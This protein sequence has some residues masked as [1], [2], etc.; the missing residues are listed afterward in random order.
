VTIALQI[1]QHVK[2][3]GANDGSKDNIEPEVK[4]VLL[5]IP[6]I[7]PFPDAIA[8]TCEKADGNK[9]AIGL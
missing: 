9:E 3:T 4:D 1:G 7:A 8:D 6:L 5:V 2:N